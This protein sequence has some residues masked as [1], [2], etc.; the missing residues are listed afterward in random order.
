MKQG[1]QAGSTVETQESDNGALYLGCR[2]E[3][4][5]KWLGPEGI[6]KVD[7]AMFAEGFHMGYEK[8][9][10]VKN[11]SKVFCLGKWR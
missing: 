2:V 10:E 9:R 6:V 1:D 11:V 3:G 5:R 8:K 7:Q 4:G